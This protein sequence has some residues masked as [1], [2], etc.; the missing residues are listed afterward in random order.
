MHDHAAIRELLEEANRLP[1][2]S[3]KLALLEEAVRLA[4][5]HQ[6]VA[7]GI[8]ARQPLMWTAR[9][10]LRGDVLAAA[11]VWSLAQYDR[12]PRLFAGRNLLTEQH[13]VI[14]QLSN[15]PDISRATLDDM[16]ADF[17]AG[18]RRPASRA[19]RSGTPSAPSRLTW[20]TWSWPARPTRRSGSTRPT[21]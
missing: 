9:T 17:G 7:L 16:L 12:E 13:W 1:E 14:G 15:I 3:A 2:S 6:D 8:A 19:A 21:P 5:L 20:A 11:F 10:L 18:W 4:D